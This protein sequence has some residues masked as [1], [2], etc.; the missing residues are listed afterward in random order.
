MDLSRGKSRS[1]NEIQVR[2]TN[3]LA[4]QPKER[5]L[6]VIVGLGRDIVVLQVLLSVE[7]DGLGLYLTLLNIDLVTAKNNG[8]VLT[9]TDEITM[10]VGDV[11]VGD[12]RGDIEHDNSTLATD[13]ITITKTTKLLLASSIPGVENDSTKVSVETERM[14]LTPRVATYFFSNSPVK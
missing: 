10:P 9:D 12:S 2:V 3:Q 5:L 4:S 14:D 7:S 13:I 8:D 1:S 6:K 11:L